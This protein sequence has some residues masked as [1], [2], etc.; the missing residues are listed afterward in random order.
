MKRALKY[1]LSALAAAVVAAPAMAGNTLDNSALYVAGTFTEASGNGLHITDLNTANDAGGS[2]WRPVMLDPDHEFD[3]YVGFSYRLAD[4]NTRFFIEYDHFKGDESRE[5]VGA[6]ALSAGVPVNIAPV[7]TANVEH[8]ERDFKFGLRHTLDFGP[9]FETVLGAGLEYSKVQRTFT[10]QSLWTG[11]NSRFREMF[12]ETEGWGPFV[13]AKG[14]AYPWGNESRNW[15]FWAR[16]AV[17]LLYSD[18]TG[19]FEMREPGVGIPQLTNNYTFTPEDTKSIITRVEADL[20][21]EWNRVMRADFNDLLLGV[22]LGVRYHNMMN[23]FKNGNLNQVVATSS[24]GGAGLTGDL[25]TSPN[26][27]GRMGPFLEFKI[28]GSNA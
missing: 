26:D 10:T 20:G 11:P 25:N 2:S 14:R 19:R 21:L 4:T 17:A 18:H 13:E 9:K 7:T 1:T 24:E 3:F 16:G 28:G 8:K 23:A 6:A 12:D 22:K 5:V 27:Y 15:S